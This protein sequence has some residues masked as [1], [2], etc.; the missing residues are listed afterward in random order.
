MRKGLKAFSR[1]KANAWIFR[2]SHFRKVSF[3]A[4]S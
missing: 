1:K 2:I 3:F 4:F